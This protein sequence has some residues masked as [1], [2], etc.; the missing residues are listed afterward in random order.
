MMEDPGGANYLAPLPEALERLG[1][2]CMSLAHPRLADT[3]TARRVPHTVVGDNPDPSDILRRSEPA[4]LIVGTAEDPNALGLA[5]IDAARHSDIPSIAVIDMIA[6]APGRF[7]G[8]SSNPLT[9]HPDWLIV[10]DAATR[11]AF[12]DLG[13]AE[14][15][16]E[17]SGHPHFDWVRSRRQ[18]LIATDRPTA[19]RRVFPNAPA[20]SPVIVFAAEGV[21]Q[22]DPTFSRRSVDYTLHGRGST[23]FRTAIVLE[24]LLDAATAMTP[25]PHIVVRMHPKSPPDELAA[26]DD[27]VDFFSSSGEALPL[28]WAADAVVGMT[29]M[30][31]I[32]AFLVGQRALSI[33]PRRAEADLLVTTA[34]T[35]IPVAASR[36]EVQQSLARLL[37]EPAPAPATNFD[38]PT[39]AVDRTARFIARRLETARNTQ[40]SDEHRTQVTNRRNCVG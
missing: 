4:L 40:H 36:D 30:V 38:L 8:R 11:D 37:T 27:E 16:I 5:L 7:R 24:E 20:G 18:E 33:V 15:R 39:G 26:Y 25:R 35:L 31:L 34:N 19:R 3:L 28:L 1:I 17:V 10:C 23:N 14:Q 6:N 22:V 29:S 32:E 12:A 21:D 2:Q 9:H 13:S